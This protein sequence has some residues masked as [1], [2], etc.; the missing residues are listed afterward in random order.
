MFRPF[1]AGA[2]VGHIA[3]ATC[4]DV[5]IEEHQY[6]AIDRRAADGASLDVASRL[7]RF[8]KRRHARLPH[9]ENEAARRSMN[10]DGFAM[11]GPGAISGAIRL[12]HWRSAATK[13]GR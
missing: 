4:V 3:D 12:L 11:L 2:M 1:K 6:V 13:L 7:K 5:A 8:P 10:A 9:E